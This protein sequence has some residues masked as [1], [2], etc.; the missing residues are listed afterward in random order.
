MFRQPAAVIVSLLCAGCFAGY[1]TPP[2]HELRVHRGTFVKEM[3]LTGELEAARGAAI[4]VPPLPTWQTSI[5]WIATDGDEVRKGERVVELDNSTFVNDLDQKRQTETQAQ[6]ELQQREAEWRSDLQQK[7]LDADKKQG[8]FEKAKIEADVPKDIVSL[9]DYEDRQLKF[10]RA[11][12]EYDKAHDLLR[13]RQK[14]VKSDRAN[15]ELKLLRA[16]RDVTTAERAISALVLT[17]P[18]DG[19][20]VVRDIPWEGRKLQTGDTVWIGFALAQIPELD[21]LQVSAALADVDDGTVVPGMPAVVTVDGYPSMHFR[22]Q[23]ASV[24]AVA[25]EGS[26]GGM[27]RMFRVVV[28]LDR[29]DRE[30]MRPGLS[31]RVEV[32]R[33]TRPNVLLAP[34][35]A[36]EIS[37]HARARLASGKTVDV[38]LGPCNAQECVV[39]S[40]LTEGARLS[41]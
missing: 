17:A 34:R 24:S 7:Q 19:I 14:S 18:R 23:V 29:V 27:R 8:D 3:V 2:Q 35:S 22:G 10:Q 5:R 31:A 37:A 28:K 12:V 32:R 16:H 26:K 15:L 1:D 33:E 38:K 4:S 21:S 20:V 30:R 41:S 6:Q 13:S 39:V 25:Q 9:R 40:G 36:L 11:R